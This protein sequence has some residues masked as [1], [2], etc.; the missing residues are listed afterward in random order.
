VVAN[1]EADDGGAAI[2]AGNERVLSARLWD[3]RFFWDQDRKRSLESRLPQLESIVFHARLG[4]LAEKTLRLQA[5]AGWLS[6]HVPGCAREL[7]VR[8]ASLCKADLVTGMVGEFPELQGVMGRYYALHDGDPAEV[9]DAIAEHYAPR[10]PNDG[11]PSA[12]VSVAVALADKL[13][14]LAGLYAIGERSTGSKDP[15][16]LRRAALGIIRL[17]LENRLRLPLRQTLA[18]ALAGYGQHLAEIDHEVVASDVIAFVADRLKVQ[19]HL[20]REGGVRH[21]LIT[22]VFTAGEEDDLVRLLAKVEAL[23]KFL[24]TDDGANLLTA[25]RR[26]A[27]IVSIEEKR[28]GRAYRDAPDPSLLVAPEEKALFQRLAVV[29]EVIEDAL[30][31]E[32]FEGAMAALARLRQPVDAFFDR[33][34][35]NVEDPK[36]RENRLY[37]LEKIRS[38]LSGIADFS[39]V[40][41]TVQSQEGKRR[42]A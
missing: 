14:A 36:L 15:F 29:G 28:D 33:V 4:T 39:V 1:I 18:H 38:A 13:D 12:P 20:L 2:D 42:V 3:A 21:D 16:A 31:R 19:I 25:Y 26:G 24:A 41:D 8:A 34:T 7:A 6:S 10:G 40:E 35:V 5:L 30:A 37:L 27:N 11:C 23:R 17:V 9:A 32:D 22:A